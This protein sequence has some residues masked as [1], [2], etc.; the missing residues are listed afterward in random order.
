V[1]PPAGSTRKKDPPAP[2]EAEPDGEQIDVEARLAELTGLVEAQSKELEERDTTIA[3]LKDEL[4]ARDATIAELEDQVGGAG[5]TTGETLATA[6]T[7][8]GETRT[9]TY[10]GRPELIGRDEEGEPTEEDVYKGVDPA[11]GNAIHLA[12]G[13]STQVSAEKAAQLETDFPGAFEIS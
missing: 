1:T 3:A 6:A 13:E 9:V 5:S 4:E 10:L 8:S 12:V 2:P 7:V 11:R